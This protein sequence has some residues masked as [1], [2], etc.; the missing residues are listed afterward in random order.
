MPTPSEEKQKI[1]EQ[2]I[3]I[4]ESIKTKTTDIKDL[5]KKLKHIGKK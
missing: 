3:R 1:K 4:R 2:K 5:K